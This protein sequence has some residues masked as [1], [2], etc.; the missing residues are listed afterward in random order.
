MSPI[1]YVCLAQCLAGSEQF[2][3]IILFQAVSFSDLRSK[4]SLTSF[5]VPPLP[6]KHASQVLRGTE[7][8]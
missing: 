2:F 7:A 1:M 6:L 3:A 4:A 5:P 8:T